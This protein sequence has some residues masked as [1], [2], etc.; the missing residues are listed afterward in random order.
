VSDFAVPLC[1]ICGAQEWADGRDR[2]P[3]C[4]HYLVA[5]P[6]PACARPR[7]FRVTWWDGSSIFS[8]ARSCDFCDSRREP[9]VGTL[10]W[11][12]WILMRMTIPDM[13]DPL[14]TGSPLVVNKKG[15]LVVMDEQRRDLVRVR[16]LLAQLF[17]LDDRGNL[18][19]RC[20]RVVDAFGWIIGAMVERGHAKC[21]E[22]ALAAPLAS[23]IAILRA[24]ART[25]GLVPLGLPFDAVTG[26]SPAVATEP[27]ADLPAVETTSPPAQN[28]ATPHS[29]I[30]F[31]ERVERMARAVG[32][33]TDGAELIRLLGARPDYT[34]TRAEIAMTMDKSAPE[35]VE[36]CLDAIRKRIGRTREKM[37]DLEP[38]HGWLTIRCEGK[39]VSLV[40]REP[41]AV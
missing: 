13:G 30:A 31:S 8:V 12:R 14:A 24:E 7:K 38:E 9:A 15:R 1:H 20:H 36:D 25:K 34:A 33:L 28:E 2:A 10:E 19:E 21:P 18:A 17:D 16:I 32:T 29:D 3:A 11:A 41:R 27:P 5:F 22:A 6:C 39:N 40:I 23:A 37:E 26:P 35:D 4:P